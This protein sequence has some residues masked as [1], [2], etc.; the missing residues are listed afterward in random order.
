MV[1]RDLSLPASV[2]LISLKRQALPGA[3]APIKTAACVVLEAQLATARQTSIANGHAQLGLLSERPLA[4]VPWLPT[5]VL[6]RVAARRAPAVLT[7]VAV[8]V[9]VG[10]EVKTAAFAEGHG[11]PT[12]LEPVGPLHLVAGR[13]RGRQGKARVLQPVRPA[14]SGAE[15]TRYAVD[16]ALAAD[17]DAQV[18]RHHR[19]G[20]P[21]PTA[22]GHG[23]DRQ[24]KYETRVCEGTRG[25]WLP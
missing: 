4:A 22:I 3:A 12:A 23:L 10:R 13:V 15:P 21:N 9:A 5:T 19:L 25:A 18:A 16:G 24:A 14:R 2:T 11:L 17:A 8:P 7:A 20:A 1:R 6:Q